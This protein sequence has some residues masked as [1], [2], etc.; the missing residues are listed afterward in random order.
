M[1]PNV[2]EDD[3]ST[4]SARLF[5]LYLTVLSA[6]TYPKYR[7]SLSKLLAAAANTLKV[8]A[9]TPVIVCIN[10]TSL[11]CKEHADPSAV[12]VL[13]SVV[14]ADAA[15]LVPAAVSSAVN[16]VWSA[17][18]DAAVTRPATCVASAL[19]LKMVLSAVI[20]SVPL[21]S[22]DPISCNVSSVDGAAPTNPAIAAF[23]SVVSANNASCVPE[24]NDENVAEFAES[25]VC[26]EC[27]WDDTAVDSDALSDTRDAAPADSAADSVESTAESDAAAVCSEVASDAMSDARPDTL[28]D[29]AADSVESAAESD[30]A[31]VCSEV[32][33]DATP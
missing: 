19:L 3:C 27:A 24:L 29:S 4:G 2:S 12:T 10:D 14:T 21:F 30:A 6:F 28:A 1:I 33:T 9:F 18:P 25:I 11:V 5:I 13:C 32:A 17:N 15:A 20:T 26:K 16:D 31:A 8:V 23:T 7:Y 22:A